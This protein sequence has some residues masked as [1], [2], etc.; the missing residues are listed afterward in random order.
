MILTAL[1]TC[2]GVS[3]SSTNRADKLSSLVQDQQPF[4]LVRVYLRNRGVDAFRPEKF[5]PVIQVER[6]I[7]RSPATTS[8][9]LKNQAGATISQTKVFPSQESRRV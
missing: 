7:Q 8:Y 2:L 9:R 4:A 5:G 3:A 1:Q 6:K